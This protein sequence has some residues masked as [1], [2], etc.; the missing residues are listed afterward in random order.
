MLGNYSADSRCQL[1]IE[2]FRNMI[3]SLENGGNNK[4]EQ[5]EF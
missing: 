2:E 4:N 3:N 5:K 1:N